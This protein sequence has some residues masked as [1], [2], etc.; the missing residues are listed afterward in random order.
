MS[1]FLF[2]FFSLKSSDEFI[3]TQ[4][5]ADGVDNGKKI[6]EIMYAYKSSDYDNIHK[7]PHF[8]CLFKTFSNF[9]NSYEG[10]HSM[11]IKEIRKIKK[12]M[13]APEFNEEIA[14]KPIQKKKSDDKAS[15]VKR[16]YEKLHRRIFSESSN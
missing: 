5:G 7:N 6:F 15:L 1:E 2:Y 11:I 16:E 12:S 10:N 4:N 13:V 9:L 8:K 3:P 14:K